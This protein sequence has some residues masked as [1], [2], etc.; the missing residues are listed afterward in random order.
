MELRH[1]RYFLATAREGNMTRAAAACHVSQPALSRQLADLE[2]ELGCELFMRGSRGVELTDEGM[3]LRKRA[4]EI[5]L[6]A[7]RA[8]LE[9]RADNAHVE[10]D[11]WIGAG[12]SHVVKLVAE[13][14][15]LIGQS[16]PGIRLRLYSGNYD[17]VI[18]RVDKGLLDF[19][20]VMGREPEQ[21]F[22]T[23]ALPGKDRWGVLMRN[24]HPLASSASLTLDDLSQERLIVSTQSH[25]V[26]PDPR[27]E[28]FQKRG[29]TVVA[30]YTLL[31][32]ASLLV[33][34]G[35]GVAVCFDGIVR[36][37]A[38]TPFAFVPLSDV[39]GVS[40]LLVHKRFQ[41]LSRAC[42]VFLRAV[43]ETC[44]AGRT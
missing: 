34:Q 11:V 37:G 27:L 22:E 35:V 18:E 5:V 6:L 42:D 26:E 4:E 12:E 10:G 36:T 31:Y 13:V 17:D 32:N 1:L 15:K 24:D 43:G 28:F 20:I 23:L 19:G 16:H 8:E 14:A 33:E 38:G 30:T 41:P 25:E 21:R 3:L 2:R 7:D 39:P 44:N 9:L 40:S 29:C